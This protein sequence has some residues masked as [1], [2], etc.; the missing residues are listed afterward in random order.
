MFNY[1]GSDP[2][3]PSGPTPGHYPQDGILI[4]GHQGVVTV[5]ASMWEQRDRIFWAVHFGL[6][7]P[8]EEAQ[9]PSNSPEPIPESR[10]IEDNPEEAFAIKAPPGYTSVKFQPLRED[11]SE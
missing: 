5:P 11:D 6:F 9:T 10:P 3:G 1:G 8:R 4:D 7:V 2:Y